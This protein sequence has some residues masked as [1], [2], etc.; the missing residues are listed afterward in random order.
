MKG[1]GTWHKLTSVSS[2]DLKIFVSVLNVK[3]LY[4]ANTNCYCQ[5]YCCCMFIFQIQPAFPARTNPGWQY[6][7]EVKVSWAGEGTAGG[8]QVLVF[9]A[10]RWSG[11]DGCLSLL[12]MHFTFPYL[13]LAHSRTVTDM[14]LS[15]PLC[16]WRW[17]WDLQWALIQP[18]RS[19]TPTIPL[20]F[21]S[22]QMLQLCTAPTDENLILGYWP[23]TSHPLLMVPIGEGKIQPRDGLILRVDS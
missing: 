23:Q 21:S 14:A 17:K 18:G 19:N 4:E 11:P 7:P 1:F 12:Q 9:A 8:K 2:F 22:T 16:V 20:S 6:V 3:T 10:W 13:P 5:R 15:Q